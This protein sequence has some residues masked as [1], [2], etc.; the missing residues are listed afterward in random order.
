MGC[1]IE[2]AAVHG[3]ISRGG[4]NKKGPICSAL[5]HLSHLIRGKNAHMNAILTL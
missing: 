2:M 4:Q 1:E 5:T 3:V